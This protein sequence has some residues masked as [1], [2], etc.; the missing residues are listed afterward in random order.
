MLILDGQQRLTTLHAM[1]KGAPP[2]WLEGKAIRTDL[3][4]NLETEEPLAKLH[5]RREF[6]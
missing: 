3:F 6:A 4:F 5:H 1:I 2:P